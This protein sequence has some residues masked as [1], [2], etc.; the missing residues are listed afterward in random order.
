MLNFRY[1]SLATNWHT[2]SRFARTRLQRWILGGVLVTL[3]LTVYGFSS[4]GRRHINSLTEKLAPHFAGA[5]PIDLDQPPTYEKLKKWEM[6]LPQHNLDLPFPEGRTG[7]YVLFKNQIQMLGWNNQLNEVLMNT[8]LA[9]KSK[10]AYVFQDYIW[11]S[12][13]YPWPE[14]K[15]REWI[16]HTPLNA[17]IS[18]PSAGGPWDPNDTAPRS[19]SERWYD[20]VCP[21]EERR[22]INTHDV[23]PAI[24]WENGDVIFNHWQ[25]LLSEAPERCIEIQPAPREEDGFGQTFDL[26]LWGTTRILPL[27]EGFRDSPVS[28]L[29]G[30]SPIV[31]SAVDKNEYLFLPRG[32]RPP[33]AAS[34][35][36]YNRM[37][38]I[39]LR[40]GDY[41][42]ACLGLAN[43]NSTFYSWNLL[44]ELPDKFNNP[45]GYEWGHNTPENVAYYLE[46]CY[47]T[48]EFIVN[49]IN[50]SRKDYV[51]AAKPGEV[52]Y[53]DVLF[54]LTND[55]TDWVDKLKEQLKPHGWN[56]IVTT[57]ELELDQEQ[58]DV[59]M[60]V[61]MDF[62][63]KAAVFIG[64]GWSS[65]TSNILHRRL[66]D[67]KPWI[68]NRFY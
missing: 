19:V 21:K 65:F 34:N 30:T 25:K 68:S 41:K 59:G 10:R 38:A 51:D 26:F 57:R 17:L 6:D 2:K 29:F 66:V 62:A 60:A 49:K 7:R 58:K 64:N 44:P 3:I 14:S 48:D 61:D 15:F 36:P 42:E 1:E 35:N 11:K 43:W 55:K 9:Y 47:P 45:P 23:K 24:Y 50:Q 22:I 16:P 27:W 53:L 63:R 52:R 13:Y 8:W 31:Q 56:T 33:V 5:Q 4:H 12:D 20:I 28:R 37:L 32:P 54:L 40:R 39:H 46:H 18:G 67:R